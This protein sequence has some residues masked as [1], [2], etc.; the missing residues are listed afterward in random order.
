M[1]TVHGKE[2]EGKIGLALQEDKRNRVKLILSVAFLDAGTA[3]VNIGF[4]GMSD[5]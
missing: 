4:N 5:L 3:P 1:Q 2:R